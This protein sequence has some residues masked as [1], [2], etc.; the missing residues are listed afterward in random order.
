MKTFAA[1]LSLGLLSLAFPLTAFAAAPDNVTGINAVLDNGKVTVTWNKVT[2]QEIASYRVFYSH[3]SI[4]KENGLYDDFDFVS[5]TENTYV[6]TSLPRTETLYVS[7]LA[8]NK[9]G[10]ESPFFAEEASVSLR[11]PASSAAASIASSAAAV[12]SVTPSVAS[13]TASSSARMVAEAATLRLLKAEKASSTGVLL[14]FSHTIAPLTGGADT[15][16][17]IVFG[18]GYN[19]PVTGAAVSGNTVLVKTY[20]LTKGT[21][22]L[23]QVTGNVKGVDAAGKPIS[24]D[25]LQLPTFVQDSASASSAAATGTYPDVTNLRLRAT[26]EGGGLYAIDTSWN[27]PDAQGVEGFLIAQSTD[28]G[29][30][31]GAALRVAGTSRGVRIPHASGKAMGISIRT[32]YADGQTSRGIFQSI[33]LGNGQSSGTASSRAPTGTLPPVGSVTGQNGKGGKLP[34]SGVNIWVLITLTG[35]AVAWKKMRLQGAEA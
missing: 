19:L 12:S 23:L 3:T 17:S 1:R 27:A 32:L 14:T 31:F 20:P 24:M 15:L 18:S 13:G 16:F 7:V 29:A 4:L 28:G 8:V 10:E 30:T 25:P 2:T 35:A 21:V 26:A 6:F 22:Y 33:V 34:E 9:Q 5:G 11:A